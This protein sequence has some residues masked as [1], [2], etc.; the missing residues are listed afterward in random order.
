M[1]TVVRDTRS[2]SKDAKRGAR[3]SGAKGIDAGIP[4]LTQWVHQL[5]NELN[6]VTM[7]NAAAAYGLD[8]HQPTEAVRENLRRVQLACLRCAALL[9]GF[10]PH[11]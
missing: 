1:S 5:R 7:A 4:D 2:G 3:T 10:P 9:Q 8:H 11:R 6:T